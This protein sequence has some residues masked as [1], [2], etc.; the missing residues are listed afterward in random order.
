MIA[1]SLQD[2]IYTRLASE[3]R[4]IIRTTVNCAKPG[5]FFGKSNV[6]HIARDVGELHEPNDTGGGVENHKN[7]CDCVQNQDDTSDFVGVHEDASGYTRPPKYDGECAQC[8]YY[9]GFLVKKT[10]RQL[11]ITTTSTR[12]GKFCRYVIFGAEW[13]RL[14]VGNSSVDKIYIIRP[15]PGPVAKNATPRPSG[16]ES[17]PRPLDY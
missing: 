15:K 14:C 9:K 2:D 4:N 8:G 12:D 10:L 6:T 3:Y 7:I 5:D 1:F 16:W 13:L 11:S 17:N